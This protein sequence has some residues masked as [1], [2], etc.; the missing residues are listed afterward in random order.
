[1]KLKKISINKTYIIALAILSMWTV[2]AF[3]TMG[4][5]IEEHKKYSKLINLS[6]KQRML[7]QKTALLCT[8]YELHGYN[9]ETSKSIESLKSSINEMDTIHNFILNN[10]T[11]DKI[12]KI[13]LDDFGLNITIQ[14]YIK[15]LNHFI[16]NPT[17]EKLRLIIDESNIVQNKSNIV[18][19]AFQNESDE[20]INNLKKRKLFILVGTLITIILEA[21]FIF[22]PLIK[23]LKKYTN[24]LEQEVKKRTKELIIFNKIF[25]N[26]KD[27]MVITDSEEKITNVNKAFTDITGYT[28]E[29]ALG[30]T[31]RVLKSGNHDKS[32]YKNMWNSLDTYGS[33]E[34]EIVNKHKSGNYVYENLTIL[35]LIDEDTKN[36]N[37]VSVFSNITERI[38]LINSL[39]YQKKQSENYLDIAQILILILDNNKNVLMINQAG[40]DLLGYSKDEIIGKNWMDNF[41]PKR[42]LKDVNEVGDSLLEKSN[43]KT[44]HENAIQTK[45]GEERILLWRNSILEDEDGET[46]GILTSGTDITDEK[47]K[48]RQLMFNNKHAQMGEMLSIIAHQWRQ[49]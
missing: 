49:P 5:I 37:Y 46:I 35:K 41:I 10:L 44:V 12:K 30:K 29:E 25:E 48:Q 26:T 15:R 6:G 7:S 3:L 36:I 14:N 38:Q 17:S 9:N 28:K 24:E 21:I 27:G 13:Y 31:P 33:W 4:S 16:I 39:E 47:E 11:S 32:F 42:L 8:N 19:Y 45:S 40:A 18:V 43:P 34:G 1:M 2:Y 23:K 20:M 22:S